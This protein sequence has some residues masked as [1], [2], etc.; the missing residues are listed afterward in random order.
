MV[1]AVA[2]WILWYPNFWC[3]R[4]RCFILSGEGEIRERQGDGVTETP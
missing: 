2:S 3:D 1:D 4:T